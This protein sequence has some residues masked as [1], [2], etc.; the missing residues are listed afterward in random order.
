MKNILSMVG[1]KD[2]SSNPSVSKLENSK[3]SLFSNLLRQV[4]FKKLDDK[5]KFHKFFHTVGKGSNNKIF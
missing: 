4:G 1:A 5:N 3:H 2:D